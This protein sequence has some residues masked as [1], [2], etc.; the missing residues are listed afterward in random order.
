MGNGPVSVVSGLAWVQQQRTS[1]HPFGGS[2]KILF[3]ELS[4]EQPSGLQRKKKERDPGQHHALSAGIAFEHSAQICVTA[5]SWRNLHPPRRL[6]SKYVTAAPT[7]IV[8][9]LRPHGRR[10]SR[11]AQTPTGQRP[12]P[13]ALCLLEAEPAIARPSQHPRRGCS[14]PFH[15]PSNAFWN[16]AV[17]NS[18]RPAPGG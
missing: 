18:Q 14:A 16:P 9:F 17:V 11:P 1:G 10:P 7:H 8:V 13:D 6:G 5:R 12:A 3:A 2:E 4:S 15:V